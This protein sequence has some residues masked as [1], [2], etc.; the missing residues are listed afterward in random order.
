VA[1]PHGR[2]QIFTLLEDRFAEF[3]RL[4]EQLAEEVRIREPD[5]LVF[6]I[7][8]VPDAP[9]QRIFYE[10]YRDRTAFDR[11]ESQPYVLRFAADRRSCVLATTVIE[12]RLKYAK[13]APLPGPAPRTG[14]PQ[15]LD[16]LPPRPDRPLPQAARRYGTV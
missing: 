6:V 7:H 10:I 1:R 11:H 15:A 13:V 12:L 4:A 9:M 5:T 14:I 3:D 8:L 2:I 16:P